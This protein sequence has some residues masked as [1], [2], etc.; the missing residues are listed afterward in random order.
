M[1][2]DSFRHYL[3]I[4]RMGFTSWLMIASAQLLSQRNQ[5]LDLSDDAPEGGL[6]CAVLCLLQEGL[7][8]PE[9]HIERGPHLLGQSG[10]L[11]VPRCEL[12][13]DSQVLGL[14][15]PLLGCLLV[16]DKIQGPPRLVRVL[17]GCL[18]P[19]ISLFEGGTHR[20]LKVTKDHFQ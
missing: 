14:A 9:D 8:M 2:Q 7:G 13:H 16:L 19:V 12:S 3:E 6:C 20:Q 10:H 5:S 15:L 1:P 17:P 4:G 18:Y 11:R